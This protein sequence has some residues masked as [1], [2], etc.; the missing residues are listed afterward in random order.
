MEFVDQLKHLC[1]CKGKKQ[2]KIMYQYV[3]LSLKSANIPLKTLFFN[4]TK[5]VKVQENISFHSRA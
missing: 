2:F 4:Q 5:I 3:Y 1:K